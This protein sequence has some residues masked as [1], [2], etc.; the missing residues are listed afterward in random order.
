[1]LEDMTMHANDVFGDPCNR[2]F[3]VM[4]F[5]LIQFSGPY[6]KCKVESVIHGG[7]GVQEY[8]CF[9]G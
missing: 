7:E 6:M 3:Y 2:S 9:N 1:M 5:N 4:T 8:W